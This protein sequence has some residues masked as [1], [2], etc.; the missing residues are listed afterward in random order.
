MLL[1]FSYGKKFIANLQSK[2]G[3]SNVPAP[4]E[5]FGAASLGLLAYPVLMAADI[6][7]HR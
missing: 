7:L 5:A 1:K 2:L 3:I 6:L 4:L